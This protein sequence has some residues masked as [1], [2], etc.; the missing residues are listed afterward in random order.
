MTVRNESPKEIGGYKLGEMLG[1]GGGGRVHRAMDSR[2]QRAVV[3]KFC[4]VSGAIDEQRFLREAALLKRVSSPHLSRCLDA[5][6][7]G[8]WLWMA[9]EDLSAETLAARV[10]RWRPRPADSLIVQWLAQLLLGLKALH[11]VRVVHRD[12]KPDNLLI[13]A[14]GLLRVSDLGL[15]FQE[16][17][18]PLTGSH[19]VVGSPEWYPPEVLTGSR[20]DHRGDIYQWALVA[21]W[22]ANGALP[23]ADV[24]PLTASSKRCFDP[25]PPLASVAPGTPPLLSDLVERNLLPDPEHRHRDA[26]ELL[27]DLLLCWPENR[28]PVSPALAA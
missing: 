1:R 8:N 12:V 17:L 4:A 10:D 22:L 16:D 23:F 18:E 25:I 14:D 15:A 21:Y 27:A 6:R 3:L 7:S 19:A 26:G 9:M 5:G 28:G 20:A 13:G 2:D 24:S 11:A